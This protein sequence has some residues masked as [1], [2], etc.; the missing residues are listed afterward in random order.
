M[1]DHWR[2]ITGIE[3][4][5]GSFAGIRLKVLSYKAFADDAISMLLLAMDLPLALLPDPAF[6]L[7]L[8]A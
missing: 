2:L 1:L 5:C 3:R 7:K 8:H 4:I 6:L